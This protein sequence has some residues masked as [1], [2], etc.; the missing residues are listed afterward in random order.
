MWYRTVT[1]FID[2]YKIYQSGVGESSDNPAT[3]PIKE[4]LKSLFDHIADLCPKEDILPGEI[5]WPHID[6]SN[7]FINDLCQVARWIEQNFEVNI[8]TTPLESNIHPK[9]GGEWM[10]LNTH[11]NFDLSRKVQIWLI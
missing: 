1:G 2:A 5:G 6:I 3:G 4:A 8:A 9:A 10:S 11:L 7:F